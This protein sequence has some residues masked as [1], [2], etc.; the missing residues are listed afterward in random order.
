MPAI[1]TAA[2]S[3][4]IMC[5]YLDVISTFVYNNRSSAAELNKGLKKSAPIAQKV[6]K[7]HKNKPYL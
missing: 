4:A 6:L 5:D 3:S 1:Q 2:R 7:L